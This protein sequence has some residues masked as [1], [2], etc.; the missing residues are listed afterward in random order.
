MVAGA[1][2]KYILIVT[3]VISVLFCFFINYFF[4]CKKNLDSKP[5]LGKEQQCAL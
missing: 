3:K 4:A 1:M 2:K 5:Y